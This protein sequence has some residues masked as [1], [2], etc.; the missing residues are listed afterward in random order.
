MK[1]GGLKCPLL[2]GW[3]LCAKHQGSQLQ[4]LVRAAQ[5]AA[6]TLDEAS[7]SHQVGWFFGCARQAAGARPSGAACREQP[8]RRRGYPGVRCLLPAAKSR[9]EAAGAGDVGAR[10]EDMNVA[11]LSSSSTLPARS[12]CRACAAAGAR[13]RPRAQRSCSPCS[14]GQPKTSMMSTRTMIL[15]AFSFRRWGAALVV[16]LRSRA[17]RAEEAGCSG[18]R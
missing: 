2:S 17:G 7:A 18:G 13:R 3:R 5:R 15:V 4:Q 1:T 10:A 9:C 11:R 12:S 6:V 14:S 16:A 8:A